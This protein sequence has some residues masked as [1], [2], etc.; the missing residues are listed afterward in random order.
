MAVAKNII[1]IIQIQRVQ[2]RAM[3]TNSQRFL[4]YW[5]RFMGILVA[6]VLLMIA[7]N[8][9][10]ISHAPALLTPAH[11]EMAQTLDL[12]KSFRDLG[13][14]GSI[15]IYDQNKNH[16]YEHH[17]TRNTTAFLPASTF[18]IFNSLVSLETGVI[19]DDVAVLTWDGIQR[20]FPA[21]NRDTNLRQAFKDS[22]VWFYQVLARRVGH[23]RM[24]DLINR[25]GY[26]DR[27]I[28]TPQQIDRFRLDG[29]LQITPKQQTEFL[30][31]LE[32]NRLPLAIIGRQ[33][34]EKSQSWTSP[35]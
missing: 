11:F 18:K 20:D 17:P 13:V 27:Q 31:K 35:L 32:S 34:F 9:W 19:A 21:W 15:V 26:G 23:S 10:L 14:E 16:F 5:L 8:H 6:T 29:P 3:R 22:T 25:V 4:R 33:P 1:P 12:S 28:G 30:Q 24:K 7:G 2:K